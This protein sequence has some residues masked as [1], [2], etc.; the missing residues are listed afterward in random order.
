[1]QYMLA[2]NEVGVWF[3]LKWLAL[4]IYLLFPIED[5]LFEIKA[6]SQTRTLLTSRIICIFY[7]MIDIKQIFCSYLLIIFVLYPACWADQLPGARVTTSCRQPLASSLARGRAEHDQRKDNVDDWLVSY[8]I[9]SELLP[10]T[11]TSPVS[12]VI[13]RSFLE[14]VDRVPCEPNHIPLGTMSVKSGRIIDPTYQ[15]VI[16]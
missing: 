12:I 2:Y 5:L 3:K 15:I 16:F 7:T 11:H 13:A 6:N 9:L 1:M 14:K 8:Q 10:L 4:I